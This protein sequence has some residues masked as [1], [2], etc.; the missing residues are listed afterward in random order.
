MNKIILAFREE[1]SPY[2]R[3][4]RRD[5]RGSLAERDEASKTL[6]RKHMRCGLRG[7]DVEGRPSKW[8][9]VE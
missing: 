2:D 8:W 1:K 6:L 9:S 5:K 7:K 4:E 3:G